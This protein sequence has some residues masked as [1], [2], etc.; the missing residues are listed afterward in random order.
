MQ[1]KVLISYRFVSIKNTV[2]HFNFLFQLEDNIVDPTTTSPDSSAE[3][4]NH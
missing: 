3:K 1:I 2:V 4:S